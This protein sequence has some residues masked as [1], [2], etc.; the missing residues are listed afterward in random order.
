MGMLNLM[1]TH[2]K[3]LEFMCYSE[4]NIRLNWLSK[5]RMSDLTSICKRILIFLWYL[6]GNTGFNEYPCENI[7]I[8]V[9]FRREYQIELAF[10]IENVGFNKYL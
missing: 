10:K 2:V 3:I 7:R 8:Y 1:N 9:V 4:E 5:L 6:A